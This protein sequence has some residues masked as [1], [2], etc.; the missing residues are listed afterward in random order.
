MAVI[1]VNAIVLSRIAIGGHRKHHAGASACP[2]SR[3]P[4]GADSEAASLGGSASSHGRRPI[5]IQPHIEPHLIVTQKI[6]AR[7]G[8]AYALKD[9]RRLVHQ[10]TQTNGA[11][12]GG[13]WG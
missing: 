10:K 11:S 4:R 7:R 5:K 9:S 1:G 6:P 2:L 13:A 8:S 3:S 12:A